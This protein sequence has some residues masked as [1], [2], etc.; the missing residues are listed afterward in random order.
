MGDDLAKGEI[1]HALYFFVLLVPASVFS[2]SRSEI[3]M[4]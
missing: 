1:L 4:F 2:V 3:V